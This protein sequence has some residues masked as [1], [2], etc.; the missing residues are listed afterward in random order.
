MPPSLLRIRLD[1]PSMWRQRVAAFAYT[2]A[3]AACA[4]SG[5]TMVTNP[6]NAPSAAAQETVRI[7]AARTTAERPTGRCADIQPFYWEIGDKAALRVR[8]RHQ[9][10]KC[11]SV[12]R[13][14]GDAN[15]ISIEMDLWCVRGRTSRRC[16]NDG[17]YPVFV[18]PQR[19]HEL[20]DNR[21]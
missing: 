19:V 18:L 17:G 5:E 10:W 6:L 4:A 3:M 13:P 16:A 11:D 2:L 9:S 7:A 12:Q 1:A 14:N 20:H 21:L 8:I 15:R